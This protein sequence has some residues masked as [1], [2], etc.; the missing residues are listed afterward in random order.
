MQSVLEE[1]KAQRMAMLVAAAGLRA[2]LAEAAVREGAAEDEVEVLR[3]ACAEGLQREQAGL[4]QVARM[5]SQMDDE[6]MRAA[7]LQ[8]G[9]AKLGEACYPAC[10]AA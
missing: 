3:M 7:V 6:A 4:E 1:G 10:H 5:G 2:T 8:A 9:M